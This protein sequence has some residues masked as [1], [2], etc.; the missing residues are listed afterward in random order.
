M[1]L[2]KKGFLILSLENNLELESSNDVFKWKDQEMSFWSNFVDVV[3]NFSNSF[4]THTTFAHVWYI[5]TS[6]C[7]GRVL[8]ASKK[9][10]NGVDLSDWS[11]KWLCIL[12]LVWLM[13]CYIY[14]HALDFKFHVILSGCFSV[15][16]LF[17]AISVSA[18]TNLFARIQQ[19]RT[20]FRS[21]KR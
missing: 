20:R 19:H 12:G 21:E 18:I 4:Q 8:L 11:K 9:L 16:P 3:K 13:F 10:K 6:F 17:P 15:L 5:H 7:I 2:Q 14:L 1:R